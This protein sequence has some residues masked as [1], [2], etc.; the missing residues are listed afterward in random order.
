MQKYE[1]AEASCENLIQM[2]FSRQDSLRA[3]KSSSNDFDLALDCLL[4]AGNQ[5]QQRRTDRFA[6]QGRGDQRGGRGGRGRAG[7]KKSAICDF[8]V[9]LSKS[10][11]AVQPRNAQYRSCSSQPYAIFVFNFWSCVKVL[12]QVVTNLYMC[13]SFKGGKGA[14]GWCWY[15]VSG[16]SKRRRL[17]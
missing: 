12:R 11:Q 9:S 5:Q 7:G 6:P 16:E 14:F 13:R 17:R 4:S 8:L 3:L 15:E 2:G 10:L 1:S